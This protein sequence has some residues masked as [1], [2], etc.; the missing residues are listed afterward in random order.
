MD[1]RELDELLEPPHAASATDRTQTASGA[2]RNRR[3]LIEAILP[4][5]PHNQRPCPA[6]PLG[7]GS[8]KPSLQAM[9]EG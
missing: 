1:G 3:R 4:V 8:L 7:V 5:E 6:R 2:E 9:V